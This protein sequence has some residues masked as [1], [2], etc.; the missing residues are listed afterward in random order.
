MRKYFPWVLL[1]LISTGLG[2]AIAISH[3]QTQLVFGFDQARDA[4]EAYA[5]WH[6]HHLKI[7]GPSTDIPG[8][9]HG[10]L[11]YY[12]LAITYFFSRTVENA[13][14]ISLPVFFLSVPV[15]GFVIQKIFK[16]FKIT[17]LTISLYVLSPLFQT[18]SRW[19]SNPTLALIITPLLL[20]SL[21]QYFAKPSFKFALFSGLFFG[22]LVQS[23]LA[24]VILLLLLPIYFWSNNTKVNFRHFFAFGL[25]FLLAVSSFL[26]AEIKFSGQGIK[27][28]TSFFLKDGPNPSA[29]GALFPLFDRAF[30]LLAV[31]ILPWSKLIGILFLAF[32][33]ITFFQKKVT[34]TDKPLIFLGTWLFGF[35]ILQ[36]VSSS[37]SGSAHILAAF[38]LPAVAIFAFL[39]SHFFSAR[40]AAIVVLFLIFFGQLNLLSRWTKANYS[41]LSVQRGMFLQAEQKLVDYTYKEAKGAHFIINSVTNP[42]G[43]NTTWAYLFEFYGQKKYGYLPYWGG[44]DQTGYLGN[45]LQKPFGE[46]LRYLILEDPSG[47]PEFYLAKAVYEEDKISDVVDE[48][49][50]GQLK[51]QKR[52]FHENKDPIPLP[53]SLQNVTP[54]LL[55]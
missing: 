41:P 48:K 2:L 47:I 4:F 13:A 26:A 1:A 30:E 22:F 14:L 42:L 19:L 54:N 37:V 34:S 6:G 55:K 27:G 32:L 20:F 8:V 33:L 17:S 15:S 3:M 35:V 12:F 40:P 45:L 52:L 49:V 21:W 31:T 46:N 18:F 25:A 43:I 44:P 16:N 24:Y 36:T 39:F 23:D 9:F 11:W 28:M 7:L 5:I 50:F 10:V 38:I 53:L 51:V 29:T